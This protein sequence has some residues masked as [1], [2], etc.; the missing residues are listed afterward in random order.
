MQRIGDFPDRK[1][2]NAVAKRLL[3]LAYESAF[4]SQQ[5]YALIF[6]MDYRRPYQR[7]HD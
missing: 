2:T 7:W 1:F 6:N 3:Q 5:V 4:S